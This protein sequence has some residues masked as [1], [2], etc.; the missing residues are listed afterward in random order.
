MLVACVSAMSSCY[1]VT[2]SQALCQ[3]LLL[4]QKTAKEPTTGFVYGWFV[5][6]TVYCIGCAVENPNVLLSFGYDVVGVF[7]VSRG[8]TDDRISGLCHSLV[9]KYLE[10]YRQRGLDNPILLYTTPRNETTIFAKMASVGLEPLAE[11]GDVRIVENVHLGTCSVRARARVL[12]SFEMDADAVYL[13]KNLEVAADRL[14]KKF[15]PDVVA[16]QLD[17]SN[18]LLR[19]DSTEKTIQGLVDQ[20]GDSGRKRRSKDDAVTQEV[21]NLTILSQ[22]TGEAAM[23]GCGTTCTP[24]VHYQKKVF[25]SASALLQLD[26]VATV[27][28]SDAVSKVVPLLAEELCNQIDQMANCMSKFSKADKICVPE[29]YH[30]WPPECGHWVTVFYPADVSD[31]DLSAYRR[32]LH[33]LLLLRCDRPHFRRANRY[34]FPEDV[35]ADPY[36][37]NTHV[38]LSTPS[39]CLVR[40]VRG[41]YQYR[42]Y[43]Q[44]RMD[45][46]GWGC[47][48]RSLQTIVS[49]FRMQG[50]T[51]QPV[52]S[53]QE[54][55]QA[56][57]SVGDKPAA[58]V[59]SKQWIGSQEVGY[60]LQKL[61]GVESKTVFVSS[62]AEL[63]SK[64][65]ELMAH[66]EAQGTP[67]MIG[68]GVLAHT[69]IGIAFNEQTGDTH[70]LILDPHYTGAEDISV[71][72]NKGW[73]GWKGASF[74]D[75]TSFY[76]LCLP[77]TPNV[78]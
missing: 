26:I 69:I 59:G 30:F 12:F 38:G 58:F 3:K 18:I 67:I 52:P 15:L 70:F 17:G 76:N 61:L 10:K 41:Q 53:H 35:A 47:A 7:C 68:G 65:R 34:A 71:I 73:C 5:K 55:Q 25:K 77:Q 22:T 9:I 11:A 8:E 50:Y 37:R 1:D 42:H 45:D 46:N 66:F 64:A 56:L 23:E 54:I 14:K 21:L 6:G 75:K 28:R 16:F 62:G 43:M 40:Q 49:W 4:F 33:R 57:V 29:A 2:V 51:E 48:Y 27:N 44:D 36:L 13:K 74:W 24:V 39:G 78:V 60:C 31:A 20:S 63:P 19:R 32:E 72:Q